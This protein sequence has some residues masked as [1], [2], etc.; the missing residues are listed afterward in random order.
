MHVERVQARADAGGHSASERTLRWIYEA[1]LRNL[2]R[3]VRE[4][5]IVWVYDNTSTDANHPLV[6]E[7]KEGEILFFAEPCP[8]WL[9]DALEL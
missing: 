2:R 8:L 6:L 1:S 3:A 5:D 9:R 7:A 4:M